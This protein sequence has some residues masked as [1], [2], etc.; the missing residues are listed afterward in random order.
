MNCFPILLGIF[1]L[2]ACTGTDIAADIDYIDSVGHINLAL[3][4][5]VQHLLGAFCPH[6]II[7]GMAK[8]ADADDDVSG[9]CQALLR[10][11]ELLLEARAAAEGYD[12][13][14][15]SHYKEFRIKALNTSTSSSPLSRIALQG[16]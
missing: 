5:I 2:G 12:R 1:N 16:I 13:V 15:A 6:F 8:Q 11:K 9:K 10:F 14:F 7:S 3:M 4:H